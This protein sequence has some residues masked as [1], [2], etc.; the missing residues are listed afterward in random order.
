MSDTRNRPADAFAARHTPRIFCI[1]RNYAKHIE[2]LGNTLSGRESVV[3]MKPV[4]CLVAPGEAITL[5]DDVGAIHYET[6]LVVEIGT[7]GRDIAPEAAREHISGIGL[8]LDLTLRDVQTDLK[9]TGEPWEKAK[10]F[11]HSAPLGP[12][13]SL[14][15]DIDLADLHFELAI[16]GQTRQHG[17]TAHMLAGVADLIAML[18]AH[19]QLL[20]GDLIFTGTPEGVG[21]L[22]PG[23]R[24]SLSA[25]RLAG[26][27]WTVA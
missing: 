14:S 11:D 6:E 15:D 9:N 10:A 24:L 12:L 16:D 13:V 20:P 8:G 2:E 21:P 5:P 19:W 27:E 23:M 7:G 22:Q 4:S 1:G 3:F 18:S 25:D 26:A 17:H